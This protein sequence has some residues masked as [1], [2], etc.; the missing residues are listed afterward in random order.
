MGEC[1]INVL[2]TPYTVSIVSELNDETLKESD[3]YCD[4]SVKDIVIRKELLQVNS[5]SV[6]KPAVFFE[7]TLRHEIVH[8]FL[9]E[10]GLHGDSWACNEEIVDWIALQLPKIQ[11]AVLSF[12]EGGIDG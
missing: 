7:K 12:D 3:G 6:A 1:K 2:G 10:S 4:T 5:D 8:A 11:E 9:F